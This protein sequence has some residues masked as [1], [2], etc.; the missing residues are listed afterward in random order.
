MK[1]FISIIVA[2]LVVGFISHLFIMY[3][4]YMNKSNI[5]ID[6]LLFLVSLNSGLGATIF[7]YCT[8]DDN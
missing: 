3:L 1:K 7:A 4:C 2:G 6:T 5:R 8:K